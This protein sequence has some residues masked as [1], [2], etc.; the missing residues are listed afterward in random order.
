[1]KAAV[2][3]DFGGADQFAIEDVNVPEPADGEV[4]ID[5]QA[6]GINPIYFKTREGIG[7]NRGWDTIPANIILGWDISGVVVES[8]SN[9]W[10]A[11]DAVFGMP[12]FPALTDGYAEFVTAPGNELARKPDGISHLEAAAIPL[13]ALT[14]WQSLFDN[15]G[16]QNGQRVLIHAGAGGVGHPAIQLAKWKGAHVTATCSARNTNFVASLGADD[17]ID[18]TQS[19]FFEKAA[20]MDVVFHMI[21]P[22]QRPESYSTLRDGGFLASITGPLSPEELKDHKVTGK[23]VTVRPNGGQMQNIAELM[24]TG[25][26][27]VHID[28]VY[29]LA[30]IAR[31]HGHVEGGHTRGKVVLDLTT[32]R[33]VSD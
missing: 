32:L 21:A 18:Y 24:Q 31:A 13:A 1:M 20:D 25:A 8:Q 33:S 30:E 27:K 28:A 11:G 7:I 12:R 19:D 17:V 23:F 2:I 5:V 6:C 9:A 14:A 15:A 16:L 22:D 29:T 4:L 26:L 10:R 3:H